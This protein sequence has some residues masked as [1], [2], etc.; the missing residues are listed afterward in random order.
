MRTL[1][2]DNYDSF[3][4]NLYQLI[5]E[6]NDEEPIVVSNDQYDWSELKVLGFDNIVISPGPGRPDNE[7]DFGICR[8]V[9]EEA[10]VPVLGVCLGHQGLGAAYGAT[11]THAPEVMHGRLSSIYHD[12][13]ALFEGI[14]TGFSA[15]RYHSL[16]VAD[17]LPPSLEKIAW[18]EDGIIMG[19]RHR[20]RP[21]W[22]VQFHPESICT[23]YGRRLLENFREI[24]RRCGQVQRDGK[25]WVSFRR[26]R[27]RARK[28]R[29]QRTGDFKIYH[30]RLSSFYDPERVFFHLFS[31]EAV[32]FWLDSSR[33]EPGLSRFSFMGGSHGPHS[34][35]VAYRSASSELTV[36][37]AGKERQSKQNIFGYLDRKLGSLQVR[38]DELP[39]DFN[40]GFVGY[41]GYELK[42]E[43]GA[44]NT[45]HSMLP[46][47]EFVLADRIIAFDHL[48]QS[49]YLLCFDEKD[50]ARRAQH[51]LDETERKLRDLAPLPE[52]ARVASSDP[53]T[54]SLDR[55][56]QTY[57]DDIRACQQHIK[58]GE[59]YEI[60]LTNQIC[61]SCSVDPLGLYR[62]LRRINPAPYAAYIR[63]N[64]AYILSSSPERFL[65]AGLDG[66]VESKPIKGTRPRG[67]TP[68]E[69]ESIREELRTSSKDRAENL[70][71]VD[72]LRNDLGRVCEVGSIHV[73]ALMQV[74]TYE[75][76]H[77][78]VSTIRGRLSGDMSVIDCIRHAFP[79][80]SMTGAPKLRTMELLDQFERRARG[81]YSG[82]IGFLGFNGAADLNIVI[83]T[84]V[85]TPTCANIGAGGAIVA[86]SDPENEFQ[87]ML[88][89]ARALIQAIA[90]TSHGPY[91]PSRYR[92]FEELITLKGSATL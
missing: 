32:A 17:E 59:T 81:V 73:P 77:Q 14:P 90:L 80:G 55:S 25:A 18:T 56:H 20:E 60:C 21:L 26:E 36:T 42:A 68:L 33:A 7:R 72:L 12:D 37:Q 48:E 39:F 3:T 49:T 45:Y 52:V 31:K 70:M 29:P 78:L 71:I 61:A 62:N 86:L 89:K 2:V 28:R 51:W 75:T 13:S 57:L 83:R 40:C 15:V 5:A 8:A 50:E 1:I 67:R 23:E 47:A 30:R 87:E 79:G 84:I 74:E 82:A 22:G 4:F 16:I 27:K 64:E 35:S 66:W 76:V 38:S 85:M 53:V 58:D 54:F 34:E 9:L 24:T 65:R 91:E 69:D 19:L 10:E 44:S 41:F 43:C 11:V 88:L 92:A 46:D 6:V 63:F